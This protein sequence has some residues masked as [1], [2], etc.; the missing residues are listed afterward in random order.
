MQINP[1]KVLF[2]PKPKNCLVSGF[3]GILLV[4][5]KDLILRKLT[6]TGNENL[7]YISLFFVVSHPNFVNPNSAFDSTSERTIALTE[8]KKVE[9]NEVMIPVYLF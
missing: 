3:Q 5:C 7:I 2:L 6:L 4:L 1:S 8:S 9:G